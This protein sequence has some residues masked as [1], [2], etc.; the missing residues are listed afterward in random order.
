MTDIAVSEPQKTE[1]VKRRSDLVAGASATGIIPTT[2]EDVWRIT[3][4]LVLAGMVPSSYD[5]GTEKKT[6]AKMTI[7]IMKGLEV[8]MG[9]ITALSTIA[10]INNRPCIW[11][12]GAVALCQRQGVVEWVKQEF[13]GAEGEDDWTAIFTIKRRL[14]SEPYIGSFS[15]KDAKRARLWNNVKKTPW[16]E[17][18]Q[19]MLMARARAYAL[20]EGFADCLSGLSIAEEVQDIPEAPKP[21]STTFLDDASIET[22]TEAQEP[23]G[24][25]EQTIE[26]EPASEPGGTS[27]YTL[28]TVM[29]DQFG[30]QHFD[31]AN[32][33]LRAYQDY[34]EA[35]FRSGPK[36]CLNFDTANVPYIDKITN[37]SVAREIAAIKGVKAPT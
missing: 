29:G 21:V 35:A 17:Y 8:G 13:T 22:R 23:E 26:N 37:K 3:D 11:G 12:D 18:P 31:N 2:I 10:V 16:I 25:E 7:G 36:T 27:A 19:R 5:G 15:V 28:I 32:E 24:L 33:Y 4:A 14:Q 9:P 6:K 34:R 1:I 30:E 20:R